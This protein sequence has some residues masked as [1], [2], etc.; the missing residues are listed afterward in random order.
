MVRFSYRMEGVIALVVLC[1]VL[2]V[3]A[4]PTIINEPGIIT[5]PGEYRLGNDI[6]ATPAAAG[7]L[8][9]CPNTTLD[10]AGYRLIGSGEAGTT[11]LL[12]GNLTEGALP[13]SNVTVKGL[14]V[15]GFDTGARID[16]HSAATISGCLARNNSI[17]MDISGKGIFLMG[18][19]F[20]ANR[21]AG[22][23]V[24]GNTTGLVADNS[25]VNTINLVLPDGA[26]D[27]GIAWNVT[28]EAGPSINGGPF[29]GGNYWGSPAGD[30]FSDRVYDCIGDGFSGH[31]YVIAGN[32]TDLLP[33]AGKKPVGEGTETVSVTWSPADPAEHTYNA[34]SIVTGNNG[35]S[36]SDPDR[37]FP[38]L[39]AGMNATIPFEVPANRSVHVTVNI[40]YEDGSS[41]ANLSETF[42][43]IDPPATETGRI[44]YFDIEGGF[45]GIITNDARDL[46]PLDLPGQYAK[47][48][49]EVRFIVTEATG[50]STIAMWGQPVHVV[51]MESA[52]KGG[53]RKLDSTLMQFI[54]PGLMPEGKTQDDLISDLADQGLAVRGNETSPGVEA[55]YNLM[56]EVT[57]L[58]CTPDGTVEKYLDSV[59][60]VHP[61]GGLTVGWLPI[62]KLSAIAQDP[63]VRYVT[64]PAPPVVMT[65]ER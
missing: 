46:Y 48:G 4:E 44:R 34:S 5:V 38:N 45:F 56:V 28:R 14:T 1:L 11:G 25:F 52:G 62:P 17:G 9:L 10:G 20:D 39:T 57:T 8:I 15:E 36:L 61:E 50:V 60:A 53:P 54:D 49:M 51:A 12:I 7:L 2:P 33:L 43:A 35:Y 6:T 19:R 21:V 58:P 32:M 64:I 40:T 26:A 55:P 59:I 24:S 42:W 29:K 22:L 41:A 63:W 30:G 23:S 27:L 37:L 47:D 16:G 65:S 13:L 18:N 31:P 3:G